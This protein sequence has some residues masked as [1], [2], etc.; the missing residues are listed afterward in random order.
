MI[1]KNPM[2]LK[3]LIKNKAKENNISAQLVMQNYMMERLLERIS[4]SEYK[5][6]FILKGGFLI[7]AIVGL[8]TRATMDLDTTLKNYPLT[9]ESI[10]MIF[11]NICTIDVEDDVMFKVER[12]TDIREVNDYQGLRVHLTANYPPLAV[13]LTVDVTTGDRITP[14]E[15]EYSFK[16]MFD[17]RDLSVMAYNLETTLAEKLETVLS[18]NIANTRPRDFYDIHVLYALR[19]FECDT[20]ILRKAL[21]E[22]TQGRGS[23][24]V[25]TE[26]KSIIENIR[27]NPQLLGFWEKYR[28]EFDYAKDI[29]FSDTCDTILLIMN[30]IR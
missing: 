28:K 4:L 18:R 12:I 3:A 15:V 5:H 17:E 11:K 25:L 7:A 23:G 26:Y 19:S 21:N 1:S 30:I 29:E 8:D 14:R 10:S 27:N 2:Q 13:P 22:T 24:N 9:H 20:D 16:L 6:N